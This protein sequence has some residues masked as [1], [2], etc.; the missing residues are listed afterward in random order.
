[1][2]SLIFYLLVLSLVLGK[3]MTIYDVAIIGAG[4]AGL[5]CAQQLQQAGYQVVVIE[6]SRGLGGRLATRR[7]QGT[8]ADHGVCYLKPKGTEFKAWLDRFISEGILQPWTDAIYELH[9][10]QIQPPTNREICYASPLGITAI[11]KSLASSLTILNNHRAIRLEQTEGWTIH[12]EHQAAAIQAKAV[13]VAI[14][15]PQAA[16][17]LDSLQS[18]LGASFWT[19]LNA[20]EFAPCI[21]AIA[22]YPEERQRDIDALDWKAIVCPQ[23]DDLGWIG[24]DSTKQQHPTQPVF[25]L[26]SSAAFARQFLEASDLQIVGAQ[27]CDR[28]AQVV[29]SWL[30]TPEVLQVHRWRYAFALNPLSQ[31]YLVANTAFPLICTGD[32][33]L[34][35]RVEH[36]FQAGRATAVAI[37]D[38]ARSSN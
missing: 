3:V 2:Q 29:A 33:C 8:H 31:P 17:L 34:G 12:F 19:T 9:A 38:K 18:D 6:K 36:A 21:S 11:A 20:V 16:M 4:I 26:Q 10:D 28:A 24:I 25:V 30:N 14:P 13:V 37:A 23:A 5:T 35:N 32:W 22:V 1:M 7:L 27:L 15:A